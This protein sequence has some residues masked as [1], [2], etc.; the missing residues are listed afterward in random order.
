MIDPACGSGH[1]LLGAFQRLLRAWQDQ[2]GDTDKW[3]LIGRALESVHGVDKNPFAV[4]IARFR[5]MIAAM[6][7]GG[8][9]LLIRQARFPAQHRSR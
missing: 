4:A 5:L 3:V 6:Q 8:L 2:S 1:F 9:K 7:A